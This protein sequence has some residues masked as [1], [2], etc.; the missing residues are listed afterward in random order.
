MVEL[1]LMQ[2]VVSPT[3]QQL[4]AQACCL[5]IASFQS[6][7]DL[8]PCPSDWQPA[9]LLPCPLV[10]Q[11][12]LF[13]LEASLLVWTLLEHWCGCQG[14]CDLKPFVKGIGLMGVKGTGL[15]GVK[16]TGLMG[17]AFPSHA[18]CQPLQGVQ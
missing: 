3:Q 13:W 18:Y 10:Q 12:L 17:I 15:V 16:G 8:S 7:S 9:C 1:T 11:G 4:A 6:H 5:A 2:Q 14:C